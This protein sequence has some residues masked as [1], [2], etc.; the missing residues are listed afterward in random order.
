MRFSTLM[1]SSI[2]SQWIP[3]PRPINL[4]RPRSSLE[5]CNSRGNQASGAEIVRPSLSSTLN[6][7][8]VILTFSA[9]GIAISCAKIFIPSPQQHYAV[10][11]QHLLNSTD[12]AAGKS[13][14]PLQ[15]DRIE[16]ELRNFILALNMNMRCFIPIA[17]VEEDTVRTN[18]EYCRHL[19]LHHTSSL[20]LRSSSAVAGDGSYSTF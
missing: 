18:P 1:S 14:A 6:V 20:A 9:A 19:L 12:L 17:C 8:S 10:P 2:S 3:C 13:T 5:A 4:Q 16:P 11:V 15:P 7:S